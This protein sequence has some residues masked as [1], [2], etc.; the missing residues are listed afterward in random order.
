MLDSSAGVSLE[1]ADAMAALALARAVETSLWMTSPR[2]VE[3]L[4][5][6]AKALRPERKMTEVRILI[7]GCWREIDEIW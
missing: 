5:A 2:S 7:I 6:A 3:V 4:C 1:V